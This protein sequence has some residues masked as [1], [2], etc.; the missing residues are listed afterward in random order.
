MNL[1]V[2]QS[3]QPPTYKPIFAEFRKIDEEQRMVF[4]YASTETRDQQGE[5]VRLEA[6]E[7]ALPDY[8]RFAN[9]REMHQPWAVG[10]AEEALIDGKGLWLG[11]HVV[12]D[13]AWAKVK[14]KVYKGFSIGGKVTAR[15]PDD[16]SVI[17]GLEL[18]EISIV[19][20]PANP[21]A[22]Y[23]VVKRVDGVLWEQPLQKWDCGIHD[24]QH[25]SKV[26][27]SSCMQER[28]LALQKA[29]PKDHR[30]KFSTHERLSADAADHAERHKKAA[31]KS[32]ADAEQHHKQAARAR[33][34]GD[35]AA[36]AIHEHLAGAAQSLADTHAR[37]AEQY[38]NLAVHHEAASA[39]PVHKEVHAMKSVNDAERDA[40]EAIAKLQASVASGATDAV[41]KGK[42]NHASE[43]REARESAMEHQEQAANHEVQASGA[44][45]E[46]R[47]ALE[48]GK[49]DEANAKQA[50]AD[51][52]DITAAHHHDLSDGFHE[53][54]AHHAEQA[55]DDDGIDHAEHGEMAKAVGAEHA[56]EAHKREGTAKMH[57]GFAADALKKGNQEHAAHHDKMAKAMRGSAGK[58]QALAKRMSDL[59]E[60]CAK[61]DKAQ[62]DINGVR[63]VSAVHGLSKTP[64]GWYDTTGVFFGKKDYSDDKRKEMANAGEAMPDGSFPIKDKGDLKDAIH[65]FGRAKNKA[66]VKEHIIARAKALKATD[67][68]PADWEG[69]TKEKTA[70]AAAPARD[71]MVA[72]LSK[73]WGGDR[74]KKL[75]DEELATAYTRETAAKAAEAIDS[76]VS[77][78]VAVPNGTA[79][80]DETAHQ[81][82]RQTAGNEKD[83]EAGTEGVEKRAARIAKGMG[84]IAA[85]ARLLEEI[86]MLRQSSAMEQLLEGDKDSEL[87]Q[88]LE[89]LCS[90]TAEVLN[91]AVAEE[92]AELLQGE[93]VETNGAPDVPQA[94][95]LAAKAIELP[96]QAAVAKALRARA[97]TA[98]T[99]VAKR[100]ELKKMADA[101][102]K[103]GHKSKSDSQRIQRIHDHCVGLGAKCGG[104][105]AEKSAGVE[106]T[107]AERDQ[108]VKAL[109]R[110]TT[111]VAAIT[112]DTQRIRDENARL[113]KELKA[114]NTRIAH[115]EAQPM[116]AKGRTG[117]AISKAQDNGSITHEQQAAGV[118]VLEKAVQAAPGEERSKALIEA[119][120]DVRVKTG[121]H[122]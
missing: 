109:D 41:T 122:Q 116:P 103:A 88:K 85:L 77:K 11:A 36:I 5:I 26:D 63:G 92:T 19:D 57:D 45:D 52:H 38:R 70:K 67:E 65:A 29:A 75:S 25:R 119:A 20:R 17:V 1:S 3:K 28:A 71:E 39:K 7:Q 59:A 84:T 99:P 47:S 31:E 24:H 55:V 112:K 117:I 43:A 94:L 42:I 53:L 14:G 73:L 80:T 100:L 97:L 46:A 21:D 15:D 32:A 22:V 102:E 110:I 60:K 9:I 106:K 76:T 40:S 66:K 27:A 8:M 96:W 115:L 49:S 78:P 82:E 44:R 93:D 121:Q 89:E 83:L 68:L 107:V 61:C 13:E 114:A 30:G 69:S 4:G 120:Y 118:N 87:P 10:T 33:E 91:A 6:I 98:G 64:D 101:F 72:Y 90:Q 79:G 37:I 95:E 113:A 108:A 34:A 54:H 74:C 18:T 104:D 81:K 56:A 16:R 86:E 62:K 2:S 58:R 105:G 12:D 111:T 35:A 23:T 50:E 48:E 51:Q